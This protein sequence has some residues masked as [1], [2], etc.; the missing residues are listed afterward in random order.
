MTSENVTHNNP[1]NR[2]LPVGAPD[3][4]EKKRGRPKEEYVPIPT[5]PDDRDIALQVIRV[6]AKPLAETIENPALWEVDKDNS[7]IQL[8][9]LS[10]ITDKVIHHDPE[11]RGYFTHNSFFQNISKKHLSSTGMPGRKIR[12]KGMA[13]FC[14]KKEAFE[15]SWILA[16]RLGIDFGKNYTITDPEETQAK[17]DNL[18]SQSGIVYDSNFEVLKELSN[19]SDDIGLYF[20]Q[21][22]TVP[23]LTA[24]EE[25]SLAKRIEA[26]RWARD[27]LPSVAANNDRHVRKRIDKLAI[28]IEDGEEAREHL[29]SANAR[30]VISIVRKY[31][32]RGVPFLDL[33]Q[34][35]NIGLMR[36]VKKFDYRRGN[37]F[38]T[39]ATWWIRQA[40]SRAIREQARTIRLPVHLGDKINQVYNA[41]RELK[42]KHGRDP[43]FEEIAEL[44][45]KPP[46]KVESLLQLSKFPI[47]LSQTNDTGDGEGDEFEDFIEDTHAKNPEE[48]TGK[49]LLK[50]QIR[51]MLNQIPPR[52]Q[53]ILELRHGLV[54]GQLYT[55]QEIGDRMGVTR[56]RVRQLEAQ[57]L[58][59]LRTSRN[60][61]ALS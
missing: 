25:V 24:E 57:G 9:K 49:V 43:S 55:L 6:L 58:R 27:E 42:Q 1:L 37:K 35:G 38:S 39:H 47:S 31:L 32:G 14:T 61:R 3:R 12:E 26:G 30:L 45:H 50:E 22:A 54:D 23:L 7:N 53:R 4:I 17:H 56:E 8:I 44:L 13:H 28:V 51:E 10:N 5:I 34:E 40:V 21:A 60:K 52:E 18:N 36:A 48:E 16:F 46:A 41:R 33:I 59:R 20:K 19:E 29:I 15:F 11:S 2:I